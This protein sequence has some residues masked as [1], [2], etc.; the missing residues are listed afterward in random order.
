MTSECLPFRQIPHTTRLFL[1]YLDF[2]PEIRP[3]YPRSPRFRDWASSEASRIEYPAERRAKVASILER[4]NR[5]WG[6][7][8]KT[9]AH[10]E[11]FRRGALALVTGQQVGLFGGPAFS[12]Y[13][14]LSTIRLAEEAGKLGIDAIPIFWLATEDHDFE[15]VDHIRILGPE[16]RPETL[17]SGA[18]PKPNVPVGS[19]SFGA[20]ISEAVQAAASL[21]AQPELAQLVAD[22]YRP[23]AGFGTAFARLFAALFSDFGVVLVDG[24]DPE[25]DQIAAPLYRA[26]LARASELSAAL[27]RRDQELGA[28]GYHQQVHVTASSTPLFVFRG[29]ERIPLHL[30][31]AG[32][33]ELGDERSTLPELEARAGSS[34]DSFSP[35]VLLRPVVEDYLLPTL[36][37]V[38]GAAEV[39]YF[40]QAGVLYQELLGRVTPVLHR[41]SATLIEPKAQALL[42]KYR[43]KL[44]DLWGG[45]ESL[46]EQMATR[47]LP[48][49]LA[50]SFDQAISAVEHSMTAI[51]E[52]LAQLDQTL[53]ESSENAASKMVYQVQNLRARAARAELRHTEVIARHAEALTNVLY[54]EKTLQERQWAGIQFLAKFG[55][56]LLP[57][58]K[59]MI[60]PDCLDHQ[61]IRL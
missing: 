56:E 1:E 37:Y 34:P 41:F 5:S 45:P 35:N 6:A 30:G 36:A 40:A 59:E 57:S 52:R 10:V 26:T 49:D 11:R 14:A 44:T 61:V 58:L 39:A 20:E 42:D 13:K 50:S 8:E 48:G 28:S 25:L 33:F 16:G 17:A 3:F 23:G 38:G 47:R 7:P 24:S 43:L 46:R 21:M 9:L 53:V 31:A 2:T 54:P 51:R 29:G 19:I 22:S 32:E 18:R 60:H 4:Q 15:E 55:R 12:L 27:L